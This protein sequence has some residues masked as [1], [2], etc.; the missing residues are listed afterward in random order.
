MDFKQK[1][2]N[3]CHRNN[4]LLCIGLD[5]EFAKIP[6]KLLKKTNPLFSFNKTIIDSTYDLV[7][8]YKPNIAF[9]EAYG[10][11]GLRQLK[12]TINYLKKNY[13]TIPIILDS[14][15]GDVSNT[16]KMY[17]KAMF[18]Y[19]QVDAVTVNPHLGFDAVAPFLE[20]KNKCTILILKT[21]NPDS[22]I[23]NDLK[24]NG[25][26]FFI[27]V[28]REIAGWRK[29]NVGLFVG[30]TYPADLRVIR[31]IFPTAPILTA[32]IGAQGAKTREAVLAGITKDKEGLICN[33][34][35]AIIYADN[36][37]VEAQKMRDF[38]EKVRY[39]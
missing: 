25:E 23:F 9:Y 27:K 29:E 2:D 39:G 34:S 18:D 14:K 4:S 6:K 15:R 10:L 33:N 30:A 8:A 35:R 28:A 7:C 32:G 5:T 36:P 11:D 22:G 16:A 19:W 26:Q 37:R 13:P 24:V 12:L 38:I 31:K 21:S 3:I 17:A 20:Y 1:L